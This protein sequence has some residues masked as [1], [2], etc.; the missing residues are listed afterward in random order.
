MSMNPAV[1]GHHDPVVLYVAPDGDD[2]WSGARPDP[3]AEHTDGP[4]ATIARARDAIRELKRAQGGLKRPVRVSIRA[5]T[6]FLPEPLVLSAEDS[7]TEQCPITYA[8][9]E[10]E[11]PV[12]SGGARIIGW[13]RTEV[14]GRAAW[15]A[16][17][18][19]VANREWYFRQLWLND[20]RR[21]RPRLPKEGFYRFEGLVDAGPET[22]WNEGQKRARYAPGD[23]RDWRNIGDVEVVAFHLWVDSHLP[24]AA[25]DESERIVT[26]TGPSI[27]RLT[28]DFASGGARYWVENVF[29]ALDTPGQWYL[30]RGTATVY[31]LPKP[32]EEPD[33][34]SVIAPR[35]GQ[36]LRFEGEVEQQRWIEH[37][38]LEGLAFMHTEW[39]L[40]AGQAGAAQ[41][42][43]TVP[44]AIVWQGARNCA[45][46]DCTIAHVGNYA[47]ELSAG[48]RDNTISGNA[49]FDLGAGGVKVGHGTSHTLVSDNEIG[50]GGHVFH[51]AVGVWIGNS[52]H[53]QVI[54]NHIHDLDYTGVSVG[55]TW[56]YGASDAVENRVEF[57]HIHHVGRG[58]LSD[59]GGIYTLGISP[60]TVLRH[61]LI[62]DSWSATY[63]GWGI[64]LDEGSSEI[65]VEDNV[66]YRTKTG[67]FHQHYGRE[68]VIRNNIFALGKEMQVTRSREEEHRS[69]SFERNIVYWTEGEL[70][71]G[72]WKN[73]NFFFD[74]NLYCHADESGESPPTEEGQARRLAYQEGCLPVTFAGASLDQWRARGMDV[75]SLIAD[76]RFRDPAH[77]DF[78]LTEDSPA[79]SLGF[80]AID[81]S[82]VGPRR[83]QQRER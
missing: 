3:N 42:A 66:V 68:N 37:V 30:D 56:G 57:N 9:H 49:M 15:A 39:D 51:A 6:Y 69:F 74:Y 17:V 33:R 58:M 21:P 7:G 47:V 19:A 41:A 25:L 72:T 48:C 61:N 27:F 26:F 55:W 52:G 80:H 63:G 46:R 67:G 44:G 13:R 40:P 32:G 24:I 78:T 64:Y 23:L 82:Q 81:I 8:A 75:H 60:G 73:G 29:E 10:G 2:A 11:K 45:V 1:S 62:H 28:E 4:F 36:V 22:P 70:L 71:S 16:H 53:N 43:V 14:N 38:R 65:V 83:P 34:V 77:D 35:L 18:P 20:E 50:D 54:H 5:G 79:F 12:I 31:Y 76:P 59:L